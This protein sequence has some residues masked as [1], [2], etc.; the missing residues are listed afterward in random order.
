MGWKFS[1]FISYNKILFMYMY[2]S[3]IPT[4]VSSVMQFLINSHTLDILRSFLLNYSS[5]IVVT[6][7]LTLNSSFV[8]M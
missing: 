5:L 4:S 6:V 8:L 1:N 2:L 3:I 7:N